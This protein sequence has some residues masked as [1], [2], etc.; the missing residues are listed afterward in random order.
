MKRIVLIAVLALATTA[1]FAQKF[2]HVNFT[3]L[4]QLAPEAD[5]ARASIAATQKEAQET[6]QAMYDEYQTKGQQYQQKAETWSQSIRESKAKELQDIQQ[7]LQEF[8]Q[9]VES[10]ISQTQQQLFAP[11]YQKANE[12]VSAIAKA[13]GY[14]YVFDSSS[15]LYVDDKQS[16]DITAEARKTLGIAEGRTLESLQAELQAQAQ[17]AQAQ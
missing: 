17:Q 1:G 10:E 3:E 6:F 7:R 9:S 14:I 2:A 4:V 15:L 12:T 13:A 5:Q 8:S 11:I 16:V